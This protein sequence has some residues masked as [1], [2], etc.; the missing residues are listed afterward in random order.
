ML[1]GVDDGSAQ[2]GALPSRSLEGSAP[3]REEAG[4]TPPGDRIQR[5]TQ[6]AR[7]R[8][9]AYG[10]G[11]ASKALKAWMPASPSPSKIVVTVLFGT[12][13]PSAAAGLANQ[14]PIW[15]SGM[16]VSSSASGRR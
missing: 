15:S 2:P 13:Q 11:P 7:A 6:R 12:A 3:D 10:S 8:A 1:P 16:T 4:R 9:P 5:P 14:T